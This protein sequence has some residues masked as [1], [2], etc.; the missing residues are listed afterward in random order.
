MAINQARARTKASGGKYKFKVPKKKFRLGNDP[1]LTKLGKERKKSVRVIGGNKKE[2]I[3]T[4]SI[5]NL[6]D[7][8][9]KKFSKAK[10]LQVVENPANRHYVRRNILTKGTVIKTEKGNARITNRPGQE[11]VINA[12]SV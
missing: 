1:T 5:V 4:T 11:G 6:F 7:K 3:L 8:K 9:T 12:V 2:R 10:I